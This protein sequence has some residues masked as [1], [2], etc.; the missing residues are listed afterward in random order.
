MISLLGNVMNKD[1]TF[2][3]FYMHRQRFKTVQRLDR[4]GDIIEFRL[5]FDE[6]FDIWVASGQL[7]NRGRKRGQFVMSR[8]N[9]TG[10]YEVGNVFIQEC[11]K[12]VAEA[13]KVYNKLPS[14]KSD[15]HRANISK[16]KQEQ[17]KD[18]DFRKRMK[19]AQDHPC[20]IDGITIFPS[21]RELA[22][23]LGYGK[24]GTRSPT[25]RYL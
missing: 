1:D 2:K 14:H 6:W 19:S 13:N 8:F 23:H 21:K 17:F 10:H 12:N 11:G 25:F 9:D 22:R 16:T 4:N 20:T 3:K 24:N 15:T 5:T 7:D 18:E